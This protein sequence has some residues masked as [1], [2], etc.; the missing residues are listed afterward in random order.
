MLEE[1]Y[2]RYF[3]QP[4]YTTIQTVVYALLLVL[5]VYLIY[6]FFLKRLDVELDKDFI[7]ALVPFII[8]GGVLRSLGPGDAE[9]FTSLLFDTP[10]IHLLVTAYAIPSIL[11]SQSL[12]K[13]MDRP[14]HHWMWIFGSVPLVLSLPLVFSMGFSNPWAP[15]MVLGTTA[16]VA[17]PLYLVSNYLPKYL[18]HLNF[19]ILAGHI[20]DG[21]STFIG[22]SFFGY[23]EKHVVPGLL[24]GFTG[25]WVML[26]L[27]IAVVWP[28]LYFIDD[29]IDSPG[30]RTW[31]KVVVLALG[32]ALGT[33]NVLTIAMGV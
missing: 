6:R 3:A 11:A 2:L 18:T 1:F 21:S 14:F 10:G 29:V 24:S 8:L 13:R 17:L 27:K 5:V 31:L 9:V 7:L 32:L 20:L 28:V 30:L 16:A 4:G 12:W 22:V 26:P 25:P 33:R 19:S 23:T 15:V